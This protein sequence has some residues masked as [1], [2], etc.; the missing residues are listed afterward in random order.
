MLRTNKVPTKIE[1]IGDSCVS[2]QKPLSLR[3]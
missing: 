3:N 2:T 1:Q